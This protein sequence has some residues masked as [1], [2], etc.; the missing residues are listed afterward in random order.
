MESRRGSRIPGEFVTSLVDL[1]PAF[2]KLGQILSTRPDFLPPEYIDELRRLQD[3]VPGF[4]YQQVRTIIAEE[5]GRDVGQAFTSFST[6]PYASASLSQVHFGTLHDG[7]QVAV[8]VQRPLIKERIEDDLVSLS[9]IINIA[10]VLFPK[11]TRN[12][13]LRGTF[14]EFVAYTR[15]E[16]DF[17]LEAQ[18]LE[19]FRENFQD[20]EDVVFPAVYWD[21]SSKRI[22]TMDRVSGFHIN[23]LRESLSL[24]NRQKLNRRLVEMEMKMFL[25]D[26]F[27]HADL[28][29]GNI[30]FQED[31]TIAVIDV[32]MYGQL[33]PV[34]RDRFL[35]YWIAIA[36][37]EKE[38]AFS[39]LLELGRKTR[40]GDQKGYFNKFSEILDE[41]YASSISERSLTRTYLEIFVAGARFGF[42]FPSQLLLQAKALTT[43]EA[44][45]IALV[46]D[47]RFSEEVRPFVMRELGRR[48]NSSSL[49][50]QF[51]RTFPEWLLFGEASRGNMLSQE[52]P[53]V[54]AW[55]E[56]AT[57]W[58]KEIDE[59]RL[60]EE[61]VRH[62]EYAVEI[63]ES[64]EKVFNFTTRFAQYPLWHPTYTGDSRVIHVSGRYVY[65]T[66]DAI[67]SIFRLDEIVDGVQL[68]SNG[69]VT[70][71][72]RNELFKWRAPLS[73][74]PM[75]DIGTCFTF[76]ELGKNRTRVHEYFYYIDNPFMDLFVNRR[77]FSSK[78]LAEHIREEL[79]GVKQIIESGQYQASDMQYLWEGITAVSRQ[80][81]AGDIGRPIRVSDGSEFRNV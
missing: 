54:S 61:E 40:D 77:W 75:I 31:G 67:G 78:A 25:S 44:L 81:H 51:A 7:T 35:L 27:F 26:A 14:R 45:A 68:L 5:L 22:L 15:R 56:V 74:F 73:I 42:M 33:T 47:F 20:W 32:G 30:F 72:A 11:L 70:G 17:S 64:L 55:T 29:P 50:Q 52:R 36:G 6:K 8:K 79:L 80:I 10:G 46:P 4:S 53:G 57:S 38:R 37:E 49:K 60:K 24:E 16:L 59:N 2:I 39:H 66:P 13:D 3:Q 65:L 9:W 28:H 69:E 1:G 62:G 63:N 58:A 19:Q 43:A 12:L 23:D 71:F 76:E 34:Q 48:S 18:T 41:F 21:Y